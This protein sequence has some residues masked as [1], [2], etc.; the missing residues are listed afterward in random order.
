M[1]YLEIARHT[2]AEYEKDERDEKGS[3][4][5]LPSPAE[6]TP[7]ATGIAQVVRR[8]LDQAPVEATVPPPDWDG[9]ICPECHWPALCRVLG[10]RDATLPNGPCPAHPSAAT[11]R[12]LE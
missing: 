7:A 3:E 10:P 12:S 8:H 4:R 6:A 11:R 1:N 5:P 2:L 9:T